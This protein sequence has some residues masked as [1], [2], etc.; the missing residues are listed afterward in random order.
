MIN[1]FLKCFRLSEG[2]GLLSSPDI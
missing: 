2:L 1:I